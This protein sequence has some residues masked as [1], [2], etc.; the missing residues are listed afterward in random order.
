MAFLPLL[1][2]GFATFSV[3]YI[4]RYTYGPFDV[5]KKFRNFVGIVWMDV[6]DNDGQNVGTYEEVGNSFI[7][8][9]F[10]CFW[11]LSTWVSFV[12]LLIAFRD[13]DFI[14]WFCCV[15]ISGFLHEMVVS[16]DGK[17]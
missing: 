7:A 3:V 1:R 16:G 4:V 13:L 14:S 8:K 6:Y 2:V 9:L 10:S 17:V 12:L 15:G 5:F 11:C